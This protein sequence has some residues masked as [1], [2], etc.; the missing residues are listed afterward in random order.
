M[1]SK[2]GVHALTR[3]LAREL[4]PEVRVNAVSPGAVEWPEAELPQE[5]RDAIVAETA[6]KRRGSPE[7][8]ARMVR[9]VRTAPRLFGYQGAPTADVAALE[10]VL[11]R[12][13]VMADDLPELAS[14]E[15]YPV[16]VAERGASVLHAQLR[17]HP[18]ARRKD[19]LHRA[20]PE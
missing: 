5:V 6:L 13:S 4:G 1:S 11:A 2:G 10:D 8:V 16:T 17:L 18:A 14:L 20:L 19:A 9:G 12:V 7:D 3:S 15:L